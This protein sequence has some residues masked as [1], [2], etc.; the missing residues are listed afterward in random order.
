MLGF[1]ARTTGLEEQTIKAA[2]RAA[3]LQEQLDKQRQAEATHDTQSVDC[4]R[5]QK[6]DIYWFGCWPYCGCIGCPPYL[7]TI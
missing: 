3:G 2:A 5:M 6:H 7:N 1:V 4:G